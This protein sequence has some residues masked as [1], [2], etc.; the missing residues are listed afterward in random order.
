MEKLKNFKNY[1][2]K[3][4][5]LI[6][7]LQILFQISNTIYLFGIWLIVLSL[8]ASWVLNKLLAEKDNIE[9]IRANLSQYKKVYI[10]II[11]PLSFLVSQLFV[12]DI[13]YKIGLLAFIN[14]DTGYKKGVLELIN[15]SPID[16]INFIG[17]TFIILH[18][19]INWEINKIEKEVSNI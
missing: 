9:K 1:H 3:M 10:F 11:V 13:G 12:V 6:I 17:I 18:L 8:Y 7:A 5:F 16:W 15:E 2:Y 4:G 19:S 14:A